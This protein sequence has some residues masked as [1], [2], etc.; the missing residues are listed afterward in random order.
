M[1]ITLLYLPEIILILSAVIPAVILIR[2]VYQEDRLDKEP[3]WLIWS[4]VKWGI[5][6][7][8]IAVVLETV[9]SAILS[10]FVEVDSILYNIIMYFGIV[11]IS[12]EG[13]K[14]YLLRKKTWDSPEFNCSFD[15]IV[16]AVTVS[17]G[18][19]L[20]ENIS[21]VFRYGLSTALVRAV[22]AVP[23]H[24]SFGVFMG[25]WYG[26]ARKYHNWGNRTL[27]KTADVLTLLVPVF[28]H[29][30]YDFICTY[31]GALTYGPL[32]FLAFVALMFLSARRTVKKAS[33]N[34]EIIRWW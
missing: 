2:K 22:T 8:F 33:R 29:G 14:Y 28:V 4:L 13:A 17:L 11:A 30:A 12:E 25:V 27:E 24:A 7:T 20:W 1:L 5:L 19:A 16:Y 6:S 34:D 31:E 26:I 21:Y 3:M 9:G 23:G 18:F 10:S 32:L 15:G